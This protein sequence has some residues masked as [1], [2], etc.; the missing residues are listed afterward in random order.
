[1]K[2]LLAI[3]IFALT[4]VSTFGHS[5]NINISPNLFLQ[6]LDER[7][8]VHTSF[9]EIPKWGKFSSNGLVYINGSE[10]WLFDTPMDDSLTMKLVDYLEQ[11]MKLAIIGFIPNHF[12][13]DC[14]AGMDILKE[15][16]IP[17][18][19]FY[20]TNELNR[21]EPHCDH[22]FKKDTTFL[23]GKLKIETFYPGEAHSPDNIVC[24]LSQEKVLFG[25]CM[26]KSKESSTLGNLS[27]ANLKEWPTS[28]KR[29]ISKYR[30]AEYVIPGHGE[31][32]DLLLLEHTL[33]LLAR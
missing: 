6:P 11:E 22:V 15:R 32:A 25:G 5:Q 17:T 9:T 26:V 2:K 14:T 1:M 10:A 19:C 20:K 3:F 4:L 31:T 16:N 23:L 13:N 28:I 8:F 7:V 30:E 12:H 18:Y 29:V 21:E 24:W 33:K 27:D